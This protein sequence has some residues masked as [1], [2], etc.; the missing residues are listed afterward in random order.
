MAEPKFIAAPWAVDP[1][2]R[3]GMAYNR[4]I[5]LDRDTDMRICFMAHDGEA[6]DAAFKATAHLIAAAP[7]LYAALRLALPAIQEGHPKAYS[8]ALL[9]LA[10]AEAT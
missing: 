9:A 2:Y 5:V 10:K 8:A 6:G 4:H 7:D 3:P 1:D